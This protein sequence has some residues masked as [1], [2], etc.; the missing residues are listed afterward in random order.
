MPKSGTNWG[1][2]IIQNDLE[3]DEMSKNCRINW[4]KRM[5]Q[6]HLK[7]LNWHKECIERLE[8]EIIEIEKK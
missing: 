5:I 8:K 2:M 6:E 3:I 1:K 4:K 7:G